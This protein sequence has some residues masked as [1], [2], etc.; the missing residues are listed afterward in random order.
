MSN[1]FLQTDPNLPPLLTHICSRFTK[2]PSTPQ[3]H[4]LS[5]ALILSFLLLSP[6]HSR[7]G[8]NLC[9]CEATGSWLWSL[10]WKDLCPIPFICWPWSGVSSAYLRLLIFLPAYLLTMKWVFNIYYQRR[11]S[12]CEPSYATLW[13]YCFNEVASIFE[14]AWPWAY[15]DPILEW[16]EM[17]STKDTIIKFFHSC[18]SPG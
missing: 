11:R 16:E 4:G 10:C 9:P 5:W 18:S 14:T 2:A 3:N 6:T 8:S 12:P 15:M 1:A 17:V 13:W 7:L